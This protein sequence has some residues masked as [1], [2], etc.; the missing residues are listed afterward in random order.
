M[1]HLYLGFRRIGRDARF[2]GIGNAMRYFFFQRIIGINGK[3]RWPVHWSSSVIQHQNI[4]LEDDSRPP[5]PGYSIGNYIQANN[6]IFFGS[7][8]RIGP[9]VKI[10]SAN[11]DLDDLSRHTPSEPIR[12][13]R[14]CW[15]SA[16]CVILPGVV[17][18]DRTI[19]G[20]GAVV[21]K[22]FPEGNCVLA[23]VPARLIRHLGSTEKVDAEEAAGLD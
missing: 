5:F 12:I 3:V 7:Q 4:R 2:L 8:T 19:V 18:G 17:L 23:G 13:G 9:G 10:I 21:T 11:H 20:A 14:R 16:N 1:C 22:S 15:L 6:G